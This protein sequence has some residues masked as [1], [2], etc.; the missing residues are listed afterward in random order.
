MKNNNTNN[1]NNIILINNYIFPKNKK[2]S[3]YILKKNLNSNI[4]KLLNDFK[5]EISFNLHREKIKER[6]TKIKK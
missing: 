1:S 6:E 5:N 3:N 4:N 2:L